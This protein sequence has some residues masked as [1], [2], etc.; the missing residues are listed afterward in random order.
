MMSGRDWEKHNKSLA[1]LLQRLEEHNLTLRREKCEFG[2]VSIDFHRH[3]FTQE[4]LK[5]SPTKI[6]AVQNCAPPASKEELVSFLQMVAYLSRYISNF[7]S[8]CKPLQK[9]TK[10]N[11][12]FEW[13]TEQEKAFKDLKAT[14]TAAPVLVPYHPD[15]ETLIIC[16]RSPEGL[17]G[18]LFQKSGKGFQPVHYVSRT[19]TDTE[20]K[21]SQIEREALAAEFTTTRLQMLGAPKF[22]LATDHKPLLPLLNNPTAKLPPRIERLTLKMQNLYFEPLLPPY[23]VC[24]HCRAV[25]L[26]HLG[27]QGVSKS[28][29]TLC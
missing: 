28:E 10:V 15:H 26:A 17:G 5:P 25:P 12:N 6:Q 19:L 21:Y 22:K 2:K 20:K 23:K 8:Q 14:I 4:G 16:D 1:Q 3:L 24:L 7:S 11:A 29:Q 9:L 27:H 18:G 13:T